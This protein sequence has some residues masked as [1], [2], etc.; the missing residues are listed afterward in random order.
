MH[1]GSPLGDA[2]IALSKECC[3]PA[4]RAE[5]TQ[6]RSPFLL[7]ALPSDTISTY[8]NHSLQGV[9]WVPAAF[10]VFPFGCWLNEPFQP[11][12]GPSMRTEKYPTISHNDNVCLHTCIVYIYITYTCLS[13]ISE[14]TEEG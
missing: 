12:P 8:L 11:V 7:R 3:T 9:V 2:P 1:P 5:Q 6:L 4:T 13:V 10:K 14:L